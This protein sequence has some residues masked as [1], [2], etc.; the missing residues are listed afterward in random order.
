M[1]IDPAMKPTDN[2]GRRTVD[3]NWETMEGAM[4]G[5]MEAIIVSS[6]EYVKMLERM[7][8]RTRN[9]LMPCMECAD[10]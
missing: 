8:R 4:E 9:H 10:F 5:E 7:V 2:H 1:T 6:S 3:E